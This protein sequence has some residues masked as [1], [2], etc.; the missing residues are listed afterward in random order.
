[1]CHLNNVVITSS[2]FSDLGWNLPSTNKKM[3]S[4][5]SDML[6]AALEQMDGIIAGNLH[7][8]KDE[9]MTFILLP[10]LFHYNSSIFS[11]SYFYFLDVYTAFRFPM[12]SS[13][14]LFS[15]FYQS[16]ILF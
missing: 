13:L 6:A 10:W 7:L 1:M 11:P 14:Y 4:D 9:V 3:M 5:A 15:N 12:V 16:Q 2:F 8:L